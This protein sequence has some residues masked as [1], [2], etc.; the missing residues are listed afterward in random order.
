MR[1]TNDPWRPCFCSIEMKYGILVEDLP[2]M[3]PVKF[4]QIISEKRFL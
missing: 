2:W 1:N 4:G 3:L